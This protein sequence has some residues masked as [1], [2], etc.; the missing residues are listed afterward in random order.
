[1][2][3]KLYSE[4]PNPKEVAKVVEALRADGIVIYPTDGVYAFGCSLHSIKAIDKIKAIRNK[5]DDELTIVC[6]DFS[7]VS[8]FARMDNAQFKILKRNLPGAFT[9]ILKASG[10]V[11]DKALGK[12]KSV[13]VR[14]PANGIPVA[15]V[16]ELD[17]PMVT[18]SV[19]DADEVIEYTTDPEL[20]HERYGHVVDMVIDGGYGDN[21]PTTL[22][23]LT[24]DEPEIIR[25][26]GG[27]LK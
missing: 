14:I 5:R 17:F 10:R 19:K 8:E 27:E 1:M 21:T 11:P 26:G 22:V 2:L 24:T 6:D 15:I 13:G 18:A 20:I 7:R 3:I 12:R 16:R 23:D 9:F 25:E 4:N